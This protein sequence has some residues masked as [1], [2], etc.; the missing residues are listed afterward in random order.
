MGVNRTGLVAVGWKHPPVPGGRQPVGRHALFLDVKIAVHGEDENDQ[1]CLGTACTPSPLVAFS[2]SGLRAVARA[3][4]QIGRAA[5]GVANM[6]VTRARV[7]CWSA[8]PGPFLFLPDPETHLLQGFPNTSV[9]QA[10][11]WASPK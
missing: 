6:V 8:R 1:G 3:M 2:D 5:Q 10:I 7:Q 11:C 4:R 9:S